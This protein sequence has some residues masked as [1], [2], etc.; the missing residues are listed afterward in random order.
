MLHVYSCSLRDRRSEVVDSLFHVASVMILDDDLFPANDFKEEI[1]AQ[2]EAGLYEDGHSF[3]SRNGILLLMAMS[4][5]RLYY[6]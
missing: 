3:S 2:D 4:R 6:L 1:E 5:W